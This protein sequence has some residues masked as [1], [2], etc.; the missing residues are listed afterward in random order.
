MV[1]I[2]ENEKVVSYEHNFLVNTHFG[3]AEPGFDP[4]YFFRY[5]TSLISFTVRDTLGRAAATRLG[6]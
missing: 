2:T 3:V 1:V 4:G 6:A 5:M